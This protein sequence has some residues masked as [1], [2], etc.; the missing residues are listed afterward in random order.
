MRD[1]FTLAL[2]ATIACTTGVAAQVADPHQIYE[3]SCAQ[4]H[5]PHAGDF[6]WN[7][8]Q[9]SDGVLVGKRSGRPVENYLSSGHGGVTS[10]E[11]D[12]LLTHFQSVRSSGQLFRQKCTICHGTALSVTRT[13]LIIVD[14]RLTGR[15]TGRDIERFLTGHGRL[16]PAE[17]SEML[18]VLTRVAE[19][20]GLKR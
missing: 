8:L 10:D 4:C 14:G 19:T 18:A 7:E 13:K 9:D 16:S 1:L 17:V 11:A 3:G 15:Y 20:Q 5:G 12:A 2:V 6:V